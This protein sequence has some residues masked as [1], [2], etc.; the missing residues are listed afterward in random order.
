MKTTNYNVISTL[1]LLAC[2]QLS[3]FAQSP[4]AFNYQGVARD[5]HGNP[6]SKQA[7]S[8][9][10]AI[11][12]EANAKESEYA[13]LHNIQTNEFGLYNLQIGKGTQIKGQFEAIKWELGNKYIQV[14]LGTG[15]DNQ[16]IE[17]GTTQLLSVPF[18]MY[19]NKAGIV[20]GD[21]DK[22]RTG[23]VT[24]NVT[25]SVSDN[26]FVP[27]FTAFNTIG[28]SRLFDNGT[29]F[30]IGT[31]TPASGTTMHMLTTTGNIEH[32]RMQN[33]NSTGFG[34]FML[35]NDVSTNYATFT[36]YGSNFAGGYP[37]VA[38]M[39]PHANM[40]AFGNN[41]G[42]FILANNG[43]VGIGIVTSGT[44]KLY[45]NA[46]QNSGYLGLGGSF[47]P[48]ANVHIGHTSSG[49][50]LRITN[51]TT[52]HLK[53]DGLEIRNT[54][55]AATILNLENSSLSL[56]TNNN[57]ILELTNTGQA[58]FSGQIQVS[59]GNP[60]LG[61]VLSSDAN[62]LA[63]WQNQTLSSLVQGNN[64]GDVL[65]WNGSS[66]VSTPKCNLFTYFYRDADGD[67][68]GDKFSPILGCAA[69]PGYVTDSTDCNDNDIN[70]NPNKI[71]FQDNDS[72]G[73]G[74]TGITILS[75][76]QPSG[77]AALSSDCDDNNFAR[78]PGAFELCNTIDDNCDFIVDEGYN[79][80][81]NINN[82]GSCGHVCN[83]PHAN[84]MCVNGSC[85]IL[86]CTAG[87]MDVNGISLDGCEVNLS[88]HCVI[89]SQV[90]ANGAT[91][92]SNQCQQ[93]NTSLNSTNWSNKPNGTSCSGGNCFNGTCVP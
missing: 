75:C 39:F 46:Q 13:E 35:Y 19:A 31:S 50:T 24:S 2:I 25:H 3:S 9:K 53:T 88:T 93:C 59:G 38:S 76:T 26:N 78:N 49:D 87:F 34:K 57:Q 73:Y 1:L 42:P 41:L 43:N 4:H 30:G 90:F 27:K 10:I 67:G 5:Q 85:E 72:D 65:V 8:I 33:T 37:G 23:N 91:N 56:G 47:L 77:Y 32:L 60:G 45:F 28:K 58:T 22:T 16:Y 48:S 80:L 81:T 7:I 6:I 82:C 18:A 17:L 54:G 11:L 84:E 66:W 79:L 89:N 55:N 21:G 70:I 71:W 12:P 20:R 61:K 74:V 52:G 83:L 63:T 68:F 36:K 44:T 14:S 29:S 92:P 62:G 15:D 64:P 51:V 69:I 86:S 40:L